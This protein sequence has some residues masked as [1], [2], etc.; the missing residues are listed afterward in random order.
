METSGGQHLPSSFVKWSAI[1]FQA[2]MGTARKQF[3]QTK[4]KII[5][6]FP[7]SISASRSLLDYWGT[8]TA[9]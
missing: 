6:H 3:G 4:K 9:V 1:Q 7:L 2:L 8:K 5:I